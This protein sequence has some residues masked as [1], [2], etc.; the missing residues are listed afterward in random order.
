MLVQQVDDPSTAKGD[1]LFMQHL[2]AAW[3]NA[4]P[5]TKAD[6]SNCVFTQGDTVV[7]IGPIKEHPSLEAFVRSFADG[8]TYIG[9][10]AWGGSPGNGSDNAQSSAA[11]GN[12]DILVTYNDGDATPPA[13]FA[14][15]NN[16]QWRAGSQNRALPKQQAAFSNGTPPSHGTSGTLGDKKEDVVPHS[17]SKNILIARHSAVRQLDQTPGAIINNRSSKSCTY[18]FYNNTTAADGSQAA[19]FTDPSPVIILDAGQGTFV[20]LDRGFKGRVQRGTDLPATWGEFQ[21]SAS[22]DGKAHGDISLEQGCDGA[23]TVSATDGTGQSNGFTQDI[24]TAAPAAAIFNKPNGER[25]LATT[26]GNWESGPNQA[27]IDWENQ[28]VGQRYAYITGGTGV[29]DVASANQCLQF[30]FY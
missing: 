25:A 9:V 18:A 11:H 20:A 17:L 19:S 2:N 21:V 24:L 14:A 8:M 16:V 3:A 6:L 26:M 30:D 1:P 12:K 4:S 10:R 27:A 5:E 28:Q 13:N 15:Q 29:P 23:A 7:R 22:D